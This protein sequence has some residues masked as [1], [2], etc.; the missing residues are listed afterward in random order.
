MNVNKW[1][2]SQVQDDEYGMSHICHKDTVL[3]KVPTELL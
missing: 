3:V 1:C 2:P